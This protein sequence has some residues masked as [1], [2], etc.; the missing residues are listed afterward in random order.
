MSTHFK[1]YNI[2]PINKNE[3]KLFFSM[4]LNLILTLY[5]YSILRNAKDVLVISYVG[6][7]LISALKLWAV[8]PAALLIMVIYTKLADYFNRLQL[9]YAL[10]AFFTGFFIVF[11]L[12]LYPNIETIQ[13]DMTLAKENYP[14]FKYVLMIAENW[15]FT[16]F[17]IMSEL[18]GSVMLS[19]MFWQLANE[20]V[21]IEQAKRFYPFFGFFGQIGLIAA[22]AVMWLFT[23]M[24][25]GWALIINNIVISISIAALV[26]IANLWFISHKVSSTAAINNAKSNKKNK[27]KPGLIE[28][29]KH[30]LSSKYI[31]LIASL[32][33]CY[34]ITINLVEGVWKKKLG[35]YFPNPQDLGNFMGQVQIYTGLTTIVVMFIGSYIL[36]KCSW[37]VAA[38]VTPLIILVTGALF[39][40]F[41]IFGTY[42]ESHFGLITV[43]TALLAVLFG[44]FQNIFSKATKYSLFDATKEISYIPLD[45]E[46]K[47]KGKA[48]ADVI[49]GRL[50]KS[51]GAIIQ[52]GLLSLIPGA[53][54]ISLAPE[55]FTIFLL[56]AFWWILS[57]RNLSIEFEKKRKVIKN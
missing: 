27:Y 50:G 40:L 34:G 18:W 39:F 47:S 57:A 26:M 55:L 16:L 48:A 28:S 9:Y 2:F 36:R 38:L 10:I 5:V 1:L 44:A 6:A 56:A 14:F 15:A 17:Y 13:P 4:S 43:S 37:K 53:T 35:A 25:L 49:G 51:G 29:F 42:F 30:I 41:I 46:L 33:V 21:S 24:N 31:G 3:Y 20:M 52:W 23:R 7:E 22:G 8:L 12:F 32:I 45:E 11:M 54:L 19:L